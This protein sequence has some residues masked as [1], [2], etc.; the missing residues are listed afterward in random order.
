MALLLSVGA[1]NAQHRALPFAKSGSVELTQNPAALADPA[2]KNIAK[3]PARIT[4]ADNQDILGGYETDNVAS[5]D[6]GIGLPGYPGTLKIAS[7][8]YDGIARFN[9]GKVTSVRYGLANA[10]TV[11]SVF[12]CGVTET[13][14]RT[15]FEQPVTAASVA[16]W[17]T[18]VLDEPYTLNLDGFE[19]LL[20]GYTYIQGSDKNA[21]E[22]YPLSV[23]D[24]ADSHTYAYGDFGD[25]IGWYGMTG[26][27]CLSVQ[28][29]VE[30]DY[31]ADDIVLSGM[32]ANMF[33]KPGASL[34]YGFYIANY[35]K[36]AP[37][38]Y[39]LN[40]DVDGKTV[41]TLDTPVAL[42]SASS[43]TFSDN[44]VLDS[45]LDLGRHAVTV[46]VAEING[47][48]P[49]VN[50]YDDVVSADFAIYNQSDVLP[51]QKHLVEHFTSTSCTYCPLGD[52]LLKS[53][54]S[55][56]NDV[57]RVSVHGIQNSYYPDP[58]YFSDCDEVMSYESLTSFPSASFNRV[59]FNFGR[60]E[61][62]TMTQSLGYN[63]GYTDRVADL[64][65]G[66]LDGMSASYPSFAN[67][68]VSATRDVYAGKLVVK[69]SGEGVERFADF[70]G[71]DAK[72]TVYLIEDDLV[73]PQLNQGTW[74]TGFSHECVLRKCVSSVYGDAINWNGKA[75]END[76]TIDWNSE[77]NA[78]NM[79][80]VAFIGRPLNASRLDDMY[81]TN[82]EMANVEEY[83]DPAGISRTL[84]GNGTATEVARYT[85]DGVR[86]K[87]PAKGLNIVKLSD[88]RTIKVMVR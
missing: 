41:K 23:V 80:V 6:E 67:I 39:K 74:E 19:A 12:L 66:V 47:T 45:E 8:L 58:F 63:A 57:A 46:S 72:L 43:V 9:G 36:S 2:K 37:A 73:A 13:G 44:I 18:V 55:K 16:G 69:V 70:M 27:G 83:R 33:N 59:M 87:S 3:A 49:T 50:T 29:I 1:A 61:G 10:T 85:A 65:S 86:L 82:T 4:L 11:K 75:Y 40:V 24:D 15:L 62:T 52:N 25:G 78:S 81:V 77:W 20:L 68:N 21:Y 22:S 71:D 30:K 76:Y 14:I 60:G 17:N 56:R 54:V 34:A 26:T 79:R 53:L 64:F 32:S 48:V 31:P 38:S 5:A 35:G 28:A 7:Y 51:R 84:S 42:T 88:G